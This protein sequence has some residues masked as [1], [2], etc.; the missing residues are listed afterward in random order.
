VISHPDPRHHPARSPV[1][2]GVSCIG[3][4]FNVVLDAIN[5][6]CGFQPRCSSLDIPKKNRP[7]FPGRSHYGAWCTSDLSG[8]AALRSFWVSGK[9]LTRR[10][11]RREN[12]ITHVR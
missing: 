9:D 11:Q 5:F 12:S 2:K 4:L 7:G 8:L 3:I 10:M 1:V 6:E